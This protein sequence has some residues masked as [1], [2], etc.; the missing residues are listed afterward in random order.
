[1]PV[2]AGA[3]NHLLVGAPGARFE[4]QADFPGRDHGRPTDG[5]ATG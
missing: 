3:P 2:V 5:T 1:M 4:A